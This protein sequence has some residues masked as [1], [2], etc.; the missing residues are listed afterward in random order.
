[1]SEVI[2]NKADIPSSVDWRKKGVVPE[3]YNQGA[4]DRV[5]AIVVTQST[6]SLWAVKTGKFKS[7][8]IKEFVNCC[9]CNKWNVTAYDCVAKLGGLASDDRSRL[10]RSVELLYK[11]LNSVPVG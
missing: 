9:N 6:E 7:A 3:V 1:M 2:L 11:R 4:N 5:A 8:S 10:D